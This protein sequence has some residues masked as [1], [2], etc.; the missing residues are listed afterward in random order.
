MTRTSLELDYKKQRGGRA[1]N[2]RD[3]GLVQRKVD[4]KTGSKQIIGLSN[5]LAETPNALIENEQR[6]I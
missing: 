5:N 4:T 6:S 3:G 1:F 2:H